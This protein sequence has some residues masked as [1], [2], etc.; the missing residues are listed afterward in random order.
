MNRTLISTLALFAVLSTPAKA[1]DWKFYAS[2]RAADGEKIVCFYDSITVAKNADGNM[3]FLAKCHSEE[4]A[5]KW[6]LG[7]EPSE[8]RLRVLDVVSQKMKDGYAP[9]VM[10]FSESLRGKADDIILH[11][12]ITNSG[13]IR[14]KIAYVREISCEKRVGRIS[15]IRVFTGGGD[16]SRYEPTEWSEIA[17]GSNGYA[18]LKL[19]CQGAGNTRWSGAPLTPSTR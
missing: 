8:I 17:P 13:S 6:L 4:A 18:L 16:N 5:T 1:A 19:V 2:G 9:P 15:A 12:E 11:E 14:P 10:R 7:D 3:R